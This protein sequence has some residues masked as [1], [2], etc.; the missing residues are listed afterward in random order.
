MLAEV[1]C[2]YVRRVL[3]RETHENVAQN[4]FALPFILRMNAEP[5]LVAI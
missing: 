4:K 5:S 1:Y 2:S 3:G